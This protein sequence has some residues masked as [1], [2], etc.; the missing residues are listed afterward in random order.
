MKTRSL[1]AAIILAVG[2]SG[3]AGAQVMVVG[4]DTKLVFND[5]GQR[6][7]R[8]PGEDLVQFYDLKDPAHPALIGALP[9]TNSV[10]GPPTNLAV[11]PDQSLALIANSL[12][13]QPVDGGTWKPVPDDRLFVVDLT[14]R[15]PK[16]I[17]TVKVGSQ[18]SGL[19][20]D[21]TGTLAL[22]ANRDGKSISVLSIHGQNVQ[23]TDTVQMND[24]VTSV[25]ITPDGKRALVAKFLAHKVAV[26]SIDDGHVQSTGYEMPAGLFPYTVTVTP[27]GHTGLAGN[28]GKADSNGNVDPVTVMDLQAS[29]PRVVDYVTAGDSVEGLVV[30]PRGDFALATI[31]NG[32]YDAAID[33]WF[34]HKTGLAV[35]LRI[36]NG[37]IS[38]ADTIEVGAFPEGAAFSP[39]G[40]Y[41]YTG[42]FASN[43]ISVLR[44]RRDG[45]LVDTHADIALPGPP[46]SLRVG[47]Q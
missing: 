47:S 35:L 32:S 34:R 13:W 43:T 33:S 3:V 1:V 38:R 7:N 24:E 44:V 2:F 16:L 4:I 15:P 28:T 36:K 41:A 19:T 6:V 40:R 14:A 22:V 30:S 20:I 42:N 5:Q 39:D 18:P 37:H 8:E 10:V 45:H 12:N 9:L 23:V 29:P 21:R 27:D 11:T 26:L 25:A 46:G 31:L 17:S